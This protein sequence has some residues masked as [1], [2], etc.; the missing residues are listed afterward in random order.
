MRWIRQYREGLKV[1]YETDSDFAHRLRHL[2]ALEVVRVD[3]VVEAFNVMCEC[4]IIPEEA[5][6]V[7]H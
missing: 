4:N 2:A 5:E 7:L 3:K 6:G 1:K